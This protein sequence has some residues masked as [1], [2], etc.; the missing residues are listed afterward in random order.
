MRVV[1]NFISVVALG[2]F[3]PAIVSPRFLNDVCKLNLGEPDDQSPPEIPVHRSLRFQNLKF[4]A[5][6]DRLQIIESEIKDIFRTRSL[7]IFNSYYENL[8]HTPLRAVGVNINCDL[9]PESSNQIDLMTEKICDALT[10]LNYFD[11]ATVDITESFVQSRTDKTRM[12]SSYS[13]K[14]VGGLNRRIDVHKKK[15]S[16]TVNYNYE[17]G[18]LDKTERNLDVLLDRYEQFCNE[19]L[20]FFSH[21]ED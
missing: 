19:F 10:Y 6:M 3:N 18:N 9:V 20:F 11:C 5:D 13:I 12:G 21:L 15:D 4:S 14:N 16:I 2:N 8:P 7:N 1:Y 17:A